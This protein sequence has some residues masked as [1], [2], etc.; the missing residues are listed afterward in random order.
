MVIVHKNKIGRKASGGRYIQFRG[1]RRFEVGHTP[2]LTSIAGHKLKKIRTKGGGEKVR[3]LTAEFANVYDQ[4]AKAF[5]KAKIKT[6]KECPANS[7]Y[8]RP[9]IMTKGTIIETDKGIA[10]I[11][12]KPGRDGTINAILIPAK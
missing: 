5:F 9:N 11:T 10:K 7:H 1:K 6:V 4:K 2:T 8:V 12:S 3:V